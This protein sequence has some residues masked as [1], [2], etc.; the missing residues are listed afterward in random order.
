M[1]QQCPNCKTNLV[2]TSHW[3]GAIESGWEAEC[4]VCGMIWKPA[5]RSRNALL[6]T[7]GS[8]TSEGDA[9]APLESFTSNDQELSHAPDDIRQ[10][11]TRSDKR[12]A[13]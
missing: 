7:E 3:L 4:E 11:E 6:E 8:A 10:P 9:G 5:A 2:Q 13:Q 12:K 1:N